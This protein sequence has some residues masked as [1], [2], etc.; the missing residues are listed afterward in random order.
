M[1]IDTRTLSVESLIVLLEADSPTDASKRF[2]LSMWPGLDCVVGCLASVFSRTPE[3]DRGVEES[4]AA[5][6]VVTPIHQSQESQGVS[7]TPKNE[8]ISEIPTLQ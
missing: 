2:N 4:V 7:V 3:I 5:P 1:K 8:T 6:L